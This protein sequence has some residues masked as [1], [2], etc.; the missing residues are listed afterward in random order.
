MVK[1]NSQINCYYNGQL[2][3]TYIESDSTPSQINGVDAVS[4]WQGSSEYDYFQL[5]SASAFPSSGSSQSDSILSNPF[6]VGGIVGGVGLAVGIGVYFGF[7]AGGGAASSS[8]AAGS[9]VG[10]SGSII[11]NHPAGPPSGGESTNP[12]DSSSSLSQGFGSF[13]EQISNITDINNFWSDFVQDPTGNIAS[14]EPANPSYG[15]SPNTTFG[16]VP[17]SETPQISGDHEQFPQHQNYADIF[18]LIDQGEQLTTEAFNQG[19]ISQDAYQHYLEQTTQIMDVI[20]QSIQQQGQ[21]GVDAATGSGT[22][23]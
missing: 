17:S 11:Q 6:V 1:I 2:E 12:S 5:S 8:G 9:S 13:D 20:N 22:G 7:F 4:P 10:G 14:V 15:N 3:Y 23:R 18:Q 16:N 21:M 19:K